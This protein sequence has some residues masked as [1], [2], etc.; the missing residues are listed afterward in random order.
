[1]PTNPDLHRQ[2]PHASS[3]GVVTAAVMARRCPPGDLADRARQ[4][5]TPCRE[6]EEMHAI[7][8]VGVDRHN[9]V[10]QVA[11]IGAPVC[12]SYDVCSKSAMPMPSTTAPSI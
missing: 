2:L 1:M 6:V 4:L 9:V 8:G 5:V 12:R 7:A 11:V 10:G 3:G